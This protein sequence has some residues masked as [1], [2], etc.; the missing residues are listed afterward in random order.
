[1][2]EGG[3]QL[4]RGRQLRGSRDAGAE[5]QHVSGRGRAGEAGERLGIGAGGCAGTFDA[6]RSCGR[7]SSA[8][9]PSAQ[10]RVSRFLLN[11]GDPTVTSGAV[12]KINA[13]NVAIVSGTPTAQN[14]WVE[15]TANVTVTDGRLTLTNAAG[16]VD[17]RI[18]FVDITDGDTIPPP[19]PP[20]PPP[21]GDS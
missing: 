7:R 17:N 16:A 5:L 12:Y 13:E 6:R 9:S 11:F 2:G 4:R 10:E 19:P 21:S 15:G 20:P 14:P 18:A 1:V 8:Q 3:L